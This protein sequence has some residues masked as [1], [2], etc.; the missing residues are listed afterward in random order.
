[1]DCFPSSKYDLLDFVAKY[2]RVGRYGFDDWQIVSRVA[3]A[4]Y[5]MLKEGKQ[6]NCPNLEEM[7]METV[8]RTL[9]DLGIDRYSISSAYLHGIPDD[10]RQLVMRI[11]PNLSEI[12]RQP[13]VEEVRQGEEPETAVAVYLPSRKPRHRVK[14]RTTR[15]MAK[16]VVLSI[17]LILT[18]YFLLPYILGVGSFHTRSST[19]LMTSSLTTYSTAMTTTITSPSTTTSPPTQITASFIQGA[20]AE[21]NKIRVS[22][23]IPPVQ[24]TNLTTAQFRALYMAR[25]DLL[26]H[27]DTKGRHPIYYYTK[28]DGGLYG[29][30]ENIYECSG[31][32]QIDANLGKQMIDLMIFNDSASEW[33]HRDSLLDPC[34]NYV[35]IG[36]AQNGSD[37]FATVYM[38]AEWIRWITPPT[39]VNGTFYA[40]GIA[41][42]PP[43]DKLND[44]RQFY[45]VLIYQ[46]VPTFNLRS[47]SIGDLYAGV[48][49]PHTNAY[50]PNIKTIYADIYNVQKV[51]DGWL[52]ELEFRFVPPDDALYTVVMFS[53]PTG[54]SWTPMSP[55]G[56]YRLKSCK[57]MEY[58]IEG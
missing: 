31:P 19:S 7:I 27:Y 58:T 4:V 5:A 18:F 16:A 13:I 54:V 50:Y 57:I 46:A 35:A 6:R 10:V 43:N 22:Y 53:Q 28:L 15:N 14:N 25:H 38:I 3:G 40:K 21:L 48:L 1:M 11:F 9:D 47:Y 17:F 26:S 44:G 51:G 52:F 56:Q 42:L 34:N 2:K 12:V 33:G 23:G 41:E 24:L 49:P 45:D 30:E 20:L 36:V 32:C 55:S 29:A 39:Y 37:V 8:V